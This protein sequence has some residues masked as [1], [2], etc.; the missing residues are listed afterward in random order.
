MDRSFDVAAMNSDSVSEEPPQA[1]QRLE[2][3]QNFQLKALLHALSFPNV[4]RVVYS[5]CSVNVEENEGVVAA[6]LK[7]VREVNSDWRIASPPRFFMW[8][9]RGLAYEPLLSQEE[10]AALIRCEP[11]DGMNGFFVA[12]FERDAA[13][14]I[15]VASSQD[16][17]SIGA[18]D[19]DAVL[20]YSRNCCQP[21]LPSRPKNPP[22]ASNIVEANTPK[23]HMRRVHPPQLDSSLFGRRKFSVS[24]K[25]L[26][27]FRTKSTKR[28][29]SK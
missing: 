17:S 13:G 12:L 6:A 18:T 20:N 11:Q 14:P 7:S 5:T 23:E 10:S 1:K 16:A 3:L 29:V 25:A 24:R 26:K 27:K 8:Q 19:G 22:G 21:G 9:R 15:T 2:S 4:R 28:I